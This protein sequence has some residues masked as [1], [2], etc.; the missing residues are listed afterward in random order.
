VAEAERNTRDGKRQTSPPHAT[1]VLQM[2][3]YGKHG[4]YGQNGRPGRSARPD[5][6]GRRHG[7]SPTLD[8]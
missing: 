2:D 6:F 7:R 3:E 8:P 5:A 4:E 1:P